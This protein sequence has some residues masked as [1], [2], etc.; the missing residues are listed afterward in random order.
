[1]I[2]DR[3]W[4]VI[5]RKAFRDLVLA[6]EVANAH[7]D[8]VLGQFPSGGGSIV[9]LHGDPVAGV[10]DPNRIEDLLEVRGATHGER[11]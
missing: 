7:L 2:D 8:N 10:R 4:V 11:A 3:N 9:V 1:M 6:D 5:K